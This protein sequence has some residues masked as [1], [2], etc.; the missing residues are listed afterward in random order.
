[1]PYRGERADRAECEASEACKED[2]ASAVTTQTVLHRPRSHK[3]SIL[4][5]LYF[6]GTRHIYRGASVAT[7]VAR[8]ED[9]P[10]LSYL[11]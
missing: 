7:T 4:G 2:P 3:G 10:E 9:L 6:K 11:L 1:M 5:R 8:V